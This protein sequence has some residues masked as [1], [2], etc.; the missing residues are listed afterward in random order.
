MDLAP[1]IQ[2]AELKLYSIHHLKPSVDLEL[3]PVY[4]DVCRGAAGA[5]VL[6]D[7]AHFAQQ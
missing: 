2:F 5:T 6:L 1:G 7:V 4:Q 3:F